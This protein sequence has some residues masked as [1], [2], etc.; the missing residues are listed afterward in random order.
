[1]VKLNADERAFLGV[2]LPQWR[3]VPGRD[4]IARSFRFADFNEAFA[5]MTRVAMIAET[6]N[7]HPEWSNVYNR[8]DIVLSSHDVGGLSWR[9]LDLARAIDAL[10]AP[11][12]PGGDPTRRSDCNASSGM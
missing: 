8:V 10:V 6:M 9:D 11:P 12:L 2:D 7:H 1:M 5:F 3:A 4:A